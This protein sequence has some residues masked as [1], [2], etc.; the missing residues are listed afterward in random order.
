MW[1]DLAMPSLG[2]GAGP[3]G[4]MP[5]GSS[6]VPNMTLDRVQAIR[7][8]V[9]RLTFSE[10]VFL[11]NILDPGDAS[12]RN[13]YTISPVSGTFGNDGVPTRPVSPVLAQ[14][15]T[16]Q[17]EIDVTTDRPF[18]SYPAVY[19]VT[20]NG[21]FGISGALLSPV[22]NTQNFDAVY[23]KIPAVRPDVAI[24]SRDIANPQSPRMVAEVG[25]DVNDPLVLGTILVDG[26]GDYAVDEGTV[27]IRKRIIRRLVTRKGSFAHLPDYGTSILDS[28]KQLARPGSAEALAAEAE[29]QI[30]LE[31]EVV[32][33]SVQ[34]VVVSPG[35]FKMVVKART[36]AGTTID[37]QV[38]LV[39]V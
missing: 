7:E 11:T 13:R 14:Y 29:A 27:N 2:Y 9:A 6:F 8:N 31:P 5:W 18:S 19:T 12:E 26:T 35:I 3:W 22:S 15:G 10:P 28:V 23:R 39:A 34:M 17:S 30:R 21:L 25:G 32:G 4:S 36:Q 24:A 1:Y 20:T 33:V 16:N 37:V 38:P